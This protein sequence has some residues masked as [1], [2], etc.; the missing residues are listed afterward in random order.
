MVIRPFNHRPTIQRYILWNAL[1]IALFEIG[2]TFPF[3]CTGPAP[4]T[5][6]PRF[7]GHRIQLVIIEQV[8]PRYS[9]L[10]LSDY[11]LTKNN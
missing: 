11:I 5:P 10:L 4:K 2:L 8:G 3:V 6:A 9:Q 7:T 1:V